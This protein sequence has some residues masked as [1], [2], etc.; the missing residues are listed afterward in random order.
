MLPRCLL[1][2]PLLGLAALPAQVDRLELGLRLRRFE[3]NLAAT[4]DTARRDAAFTRLDRAVQSF[5]RLDLGA[6]AAAIASAEAALAAHPPD[7]DERLAA[8]LQLTLPARLV[9]AEAELAF[10]LQRSF[11]EG[12]ELPADLVLRVEVVGSEAQVELPVA[13]LPLAGTLPCRGVPAGDHV[14]R[15]HLSRRERALPARE[16]FVSIVVDREARLLALDA[17]ANQAGPDLDGRTLVAQARLLRGMTRGRAEETVLPGARLLAEAE[18][19]ARAVAAGEAFHGRA[20]PGEHW[21]RVPAG[22]SAFAVRLLV[23]AAAA[24]GSPPLVLAL[25][26][27]GGSENLFFDGY[28][29]GEIVRQCTARGFYLCAP[30]AGLGAPDLGALLDALAARYPFDRDR[31]LLVGHSMGAAMAVAAASREPGR[32][33]AVAALGGG[34]EVQASEPLRR[35]PFFVGIGSRDFLRGGAERLHLRLQALQVPVAWHE[36]P[37]VEHLAI[38]QVALPEVFAWFD[39]LPP[40]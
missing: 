10:T 24:E 35:L 30:R 37:G 7:A 6:A 40:R 28:G 3:R 29:D 2:L 19:L 21:L 9:D 20:R 4:E 33:A 38:V 25:H 14:L 22:K 31:V 8:S 27:A 12:D 15:W 5:F 39:A 26:G 11:A 32:F 16:A 17:A 13:A 34:G 1:L 18:D 36:Y 23:P